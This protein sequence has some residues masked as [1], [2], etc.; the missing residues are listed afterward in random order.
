MEKFA[1]MALL[2][3]FYG[4]LLTEK[5]RKI[6]G[7][8]YDQ[9]FSLGEIAETE[10]ISRQAVH[11]LIKRT[12]KILYGYEEKLGLAG[13]FL[14]EREKLLAVTKRLQR[15]EAKDFRDEGFWL[16]YLEVKTK[17]EDIYQGIAGDS[18]NGSLD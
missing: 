3:D 11:D 7:L 16:R 15:F 8:H 18:P 5:Q 17:I 13:R 1:H 10:R 14:Q 12:E 6:W 2:A 4:P 9:D